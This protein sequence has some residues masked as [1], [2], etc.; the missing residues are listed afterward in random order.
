MGRQTTV[1]AGYVISKEDLEDWSEREEK[2]NPL[3]K[4]CLIGKDGAISLAIDY[5]LRREKLD[6]LSS[7]QHP[8][9]L[10][11]GGC[12]YHC[13]QSNYIFY[14]RR[15]TVS[16]MA[17]AKPR[18]WK[19]L[20]ESQADIEAKAQLETALHIKLSKWTI[21]IW[22]PRAM[23]YDPPLELFEGGKPE[24]VEELQNGPPGPCGAAPP[25]KP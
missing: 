20:Q 14:R 11:H 17:N 23:L 22:G 7:Q 8:P 10:E 13:E 9:K 12:G 3:Y 25:P 15:G 5:Y 6:H 24:L 19:R 16:S 2:V 21:I 18:D 4:K 1:F